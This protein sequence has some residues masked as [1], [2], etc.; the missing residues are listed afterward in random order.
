ML[1]SRATKWF[2]ILLLPTIYG[3]HEHVLWSFWW[4]SSAAL[5][6][7]YIFETLT[8]TC[9]QGCTSQV[10][11]FKQSSL[12]YT[13]ALRYPGW[14]GTWGITKAQH[15][16]LSTHIAIAVLSWRWTR[17]HTNANEMM[18]LNHWGCKLVEPMKIL[19]EIKDIRE[20]LLWKQQS[21]W[22][23]NQKKSIFFVFSVQLE[24]CIVSTFFYLSCL[25]TWPPVAKGVP[26]SFCPEACWPI[27]EAGFFSKRTSTLSASDPPSHAV[28]WAD[29][30]DLWGPAMGKAQWSVWLFAKWERFEYPSTLAEACAEA[31]Q[32]QRSW[33]RALLPYLE[34]TVLLWLFLD[35]G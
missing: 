27:L 34:E 10:C 6:L 3:V 9:W 17:A 14:P 29:A 16:S 24:N 25:H 2:I 33:L 22:A 28:L 31:I 13:N 19:L 32:T 11:L 23:A 4:H 15:Q 5:S 30:G 1:A 12:V 8:C 35:K 20:L 21:V 7:W 26:G 18:T